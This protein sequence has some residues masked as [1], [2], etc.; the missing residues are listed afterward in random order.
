MIF[1]VLLASFAVMPTSLVGVLFLQ[2]TAY[3]FL[4]NKLSFLVSFSAGVFLVTAGAIGLEVFEQVSSVWMGAGLITIG[5]LLASSLHAILPETHH[6]HDTECNH[7]HGAARKLIIGDA[8]HNMAD[9]IVIVT[10][11]AA[12]ATLGLAATLSII[13]HEA[14]QEI[15]EFFVLRKAGYSVRKALTINFVVSGTILIGVGLGYFAL[16]SHELEVLLLAISSGFFIHVV[17]HDLLPKRSQY[18]GTN[19]FLKHLLLVVLGVILMGVIAG[20]IKDSHEHADGKKENSI[21]L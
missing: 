16:A 6:H 8:I 10:A 11:F 12:S 9:G 20:A 18:K 19:K 21:S 7:S 5:Y 3:Q 15:S 17:V 4:E 13:V 1:Q 2:K 14:L